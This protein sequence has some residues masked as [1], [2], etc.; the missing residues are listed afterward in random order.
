VPNV[1]KYYA[2]K[3]Y[4]EIFFTSA[5]VGGEWSASH[6]GRFIPGEK[7]PGTKWIRGW[8][9]HRIDLQPVV[10]RYS[11]YATLKYTYEN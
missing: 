10:S 6:P 2:M 7:G 5:L 1:I 3:T 9:G 11:G 8:V 4:G